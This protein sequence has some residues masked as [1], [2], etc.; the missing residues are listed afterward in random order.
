M[1]DVFISYKREDRDRVQLIARTL[2]EEGFSVWWD[3]A[4]TLGASYAAAIR[5][6]LD[7]AST[8]LVVWS[9]Q[10][11][12]SEWVQEEAT[13]GKK[14]GLLVPCRI[15]NVEAP[16]GFTMSQTADL[17]A[18]R[19]QRD[20]GEW[21]KLVAQV[22]ANAKRE[23]LAHFSST[24]RA[25]VRRPFKLRP[26]MIMAG[27][28]MALTAVAAM[29][30]GPG[31]YE[32]WRADPPAV[33]LAGQGG[34]VT[35]GVFSRDGAKIFTA[36]E[37]GDVHAYHTSDGYPIG[38]VEALDASATRIAWAEDG[39]V[40]AVGGNDGSAAI[41]DATNLTL[42]AQATRADLARRL[43][44]P[45]PSA[46]VFLAAGPDGQLVWIEQDGAMSVCLPN[47][48][49][50]ACALQRV[51]VAGAAGMRLAGVAQLGDLGM[52]V[53]S[54]PKPAFWGPSQC[55]TDFCAPGDYTDQV[56]WPREFEFDAS[57][58]A[59][60]AVGHRYNQSA[61]ALG[62]KSGLIEIIDT[63]LLWGDVGDLS[64]A[65]RRLHGHTDAILALAVSPNTRVLAS[66]SADRTIRFWDV[67]SGGELGM[68]RTGSASPF[69]A[70]SPD[71]QFLLA[72]G[73]GGAAGLWPTPSVAHGE[74][75]A[76]APAETEAP[77]EAEASVGE[78]P[79]AAEE[80]ASTTP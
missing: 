77:A 51:P 14:R 35:A 37:R 68:L 34:T 53:G 8:V 6:E 67:A 60:I 59:A 29:I 46:V 76:P 57:L 2:Q 52:V 32:N 15:D 69:L 22:A 66:A 58:T 13:L 80:P 21:R 9:N 41:I 12:H 7:A 54:R 40:L 24:P 73:S 4:I 62:G 10:S 63:R 42:V 61:I 71:G 16:I 31:L 11:V 1:A 20:H 38:A 49:T 23:A 39:D 70:F 47:L 19:G 48:E 65:A 3:P 36:D 45:A 26:W 27:A 18:W 33:Q 64:R 75:P 25:R 17:V 30:V 55:S 56:P 44:R 79:A 28:A 74:A 50:R 5:A 43:S 72:R 78:P